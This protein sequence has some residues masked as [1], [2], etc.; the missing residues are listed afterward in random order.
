MCESK[1]KT[2]KGLVT[3]CETYCVGKKPNDRPVM[4]IPS[5]RQSMALQQRI[6][7]T[8]LPQCVPVVPTHC[9][10]VKQVTQV[11]SLAV[12]HMPHLILRFIDNKQEMGLATWDRLMFQ[13]VHPVSYLGMPMGQR[14]LCSADKNSPR[15]SATTFDNSEHVY[16]RKISF[17]ANC[18]CCKSKQK[19]SGILTNAEGGQSWH[20]STCVT[21]FNSSDICV[22]RQIFYTRLVN[23]P[24]RRGGRM[25]QTF[26]SWRKEFSLTWF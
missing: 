22:W 13:R 25:A 26:L 18:N 15:S 11:A 21:T 24:A 8:E 5:I 7:N 14:W 1:C 2:E 20:Q 17:L 9:G 16:S 3:Y 19:S 12:S 23:R 10:R 6:Q 4:M